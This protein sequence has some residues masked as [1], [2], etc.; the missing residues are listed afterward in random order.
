LLYPKLTYRLRGVLYDIYNKLGP[1]YKEKVYCEALRKKLMEEKIPFEE[2]VAAPVYLDKKL[3]GRHKVDLVV[4]KKII[5][6]VKAVLEIH[7]QFKSQLVS[8]LRATG[9]KLGF[10]VNF[11]SR[12]LD[13]VTFRNTK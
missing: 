13:I 1:G 2:E 10:L 6:E 11:G 5:I 12:P 4:D 9:L 3:V 7:P 8:Y